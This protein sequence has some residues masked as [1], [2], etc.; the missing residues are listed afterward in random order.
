MPSLAP[1]G[2]FDQDNTTPSPTE[3]ENGCMDAWIWCPNES[4]TCLAGGSGWSIDVEGGSTTG[5]TGCQIWTNSTCESSG[6][7]VGSADFSR[8]YATVT[9]NPGY[10]AASVSLYGGKC[11]GSDGGDSYRKSCGCKPDMVAQYSSEPTSFPI[12]K[13]FSTYPGGYTFTDHDMSTAGWGGDYS[14]FPLGDGNRQYVSAHLT[15][16]PCPTTL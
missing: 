11:E 13:T 12:Q 5:C 14:V 1:S 8:H 9:L 10:V 16:C 6:I 3:G 15:V 4:S 7:M 2:F